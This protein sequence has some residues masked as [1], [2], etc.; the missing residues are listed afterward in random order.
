MTR[1]DVYSK[2]EYNGKYD[3]NVKTKLR[4]LIKENKDNEEM[5]LLLL[6]IQKELET[7][8]AKISLNKVKKQESIE[9]KT[10]VVINNTKEKNKY[11]KKIESKKKKD[12]SSKKKKNKKKRKKTSLTSVI[13]KILIILF[14]FL[15]LFSSISTVFSYF[16][17][18]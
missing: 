18:S 1:E 3:T 2:L 6:E 13:G 5:H 17:N 12:I 7:G 16:G 10:E 11:F 14:I 8:K 4:N 9:E 15:M